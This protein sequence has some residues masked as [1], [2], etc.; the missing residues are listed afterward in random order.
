MD[1]FSLAD[2]KPEPIDTDKGLLS[3]GEMPEKP[4]PIDPIET[5]KAWKASPNPKTSGA[6]LSAIGPDIEAAVRS[7]TGGNDLV[8]MGYARRLTME[9][10]PKYDPDKASIRTYLNR[11]LQPL[12]RWNA[13]RNVGVKL[14][15][16]MVAEYHSLKRISDDL[17]GELGRE[18]STEEIADRSGIPVKRIAKV[19]KNIPYILSGSA[20]VDQGDDGDQTTAEDLP[21]E[22]NGMEEWANFVRDDLGNVDRVILDHSLG[23]NGAKPLSNQQIAKKLRITPAAVSQRRLRIQALLDRRDSISPFR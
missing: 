22:V 19:R 6:M 2:D 7:H 3:L 14:P 4:K 17:Y 16:R 18:P 23:L 20:V 5:F 9:A 11:Q 10:M 12:I 21:V 13:R 8:A 15:E 1:P